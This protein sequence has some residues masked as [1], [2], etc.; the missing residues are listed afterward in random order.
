LEQ[1]IAQFSDFVMAG[2][3][4]A[5]HQKGMALLRREMDA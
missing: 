3:D 4:R 1:T 2:L 5:I